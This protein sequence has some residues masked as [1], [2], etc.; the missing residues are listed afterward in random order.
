MDAVTIRDVL[1]N[2]VS[3]DLD[4]RRK[5]ILLSVLALADFGTI[6]LY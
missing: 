3:E 2:G 4:R 5:I 1:R 6:A